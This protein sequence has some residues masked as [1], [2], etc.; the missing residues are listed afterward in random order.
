MSL[1]ILGM[2]GLILAILVKVLGFKYL[3]GVLICMFLLTKMK[4]STSPDTM[5]HLA[6]LSYKIPILVS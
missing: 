5:G 2:D 6:I 1:L 4:W 3:F